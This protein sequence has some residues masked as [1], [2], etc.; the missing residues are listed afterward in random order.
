MPGFRPAVSSPRARD[1]PT[2][3]LQLPLPP[4]GEQEAKRPCGVTASVQFGEAAP[5]SGRGR[6]A[7]NPRAGAN[8]P[9]ASRKRVFPGEQSVSDRNLPTPGDAELP[10]HVAM[11][12]G[13]SW[14]DAQ[15]LADL[16]VRATRG[17][18][19]DDLELTRC[20]AR[21]DLMSASCMQAKLTTHDARGLLTERR[22][23]R[24]TTPLS[25]RGPRDGHPTGA[26]HEA[27]GE[28]RRPARSASEAESVLGLHHLVDLRR[29]LVDDRRAGVSEVPLD[30]VL[31]E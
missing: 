24:T 28:R 16:L 15:P 22:I 9:E 30:A 14:R 2:P 12:L 6:G 19:L 17:D 3:G 7:V 18:Q 31:A 8:R 23:W 25:A 21:R 29:A 13:G 1:Y 5:A 20:D 4:W 11:C 26:A 10:E 27:S